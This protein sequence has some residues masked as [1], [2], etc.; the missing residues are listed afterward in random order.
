MLT[1]DFN[2]D[3]PPDLIAQQPTERRDQSRLLVLHRNENRLE[4]R[5]FREIVSYFQPGDVLVL[6]DSRVI[7][8][9]LRGTNAKSGG[10]FEIIDRSR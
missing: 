5:Q 7:R 1:A 10:A 3:L 2:F 6:N 9:R 4:H 8:A